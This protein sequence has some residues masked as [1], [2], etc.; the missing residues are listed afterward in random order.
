MN[1]NTYY[2]KY[3]KKVQHI[4]IDDNWVKYSNNK[5]HEEKLELM[6]N[7]IQDVTILI[8]REELLCIN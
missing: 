2:K 5:R 7:E 3:L 8:G 4:E 1:D 6:K